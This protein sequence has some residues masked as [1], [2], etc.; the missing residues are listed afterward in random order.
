LSSLLDVDVA[1]RK[2]LEKFFTLESETLP[3]PNIVGRVLAENIV[4][5]IDLPIF[6]N[7]SMDGF[8]VRSIDLV[9]ASRENPQTL[10]VVDDI[11]AGKV[12]QFLINRDQ[13]S[14][15]MTGA[16]LPM[17]ADA[18]VPLEDTNQ[19]KPVNQS[20]PLPSKIKVFRSVLQGD[21]VRHKGED[22]KSGEIVLSS[23]KRIRPQE[24]GLLAMLGITETPIVRKPRIAIMS[25]GN[26]LVPIDTPLQVGQIHDSNTYTLR[27]QIIR[28]GGELIYSG[29]ASDLETAVF[30]VLTN[31]VS[32]DVDM[33][34]STAGVSV[35]A[36]DFV[37]SV[38]EQHGNVEFW[39]VNMR[40]GKPLTFGDFQG[41]PFIGLPGNP[42]SAF[43]SYEIF[44]RPAIYRM[45]GVEQS[46]QLIVQVR[47][48]DPVESDG[49]ESYL[50]AFVKRQEDQWIARLTGHQGSGNLR[51]LI[52]ANALLV[53]PSGVKSL[54]SNSVLDAI[55]FID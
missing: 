37:K 21:Y 32:S 2:I 4:S 26:E 24:I 13:T 34:I 31:A 38:I 41:I 17:G 15:I 40:P 44:V 16:P 1:R 36:F 3:I 49:R 28:D 33:I 19:F 30:E 8:A 27:A 6:P 45:S 39:R 51:S 20:E 9:G 10:K 50:R 43:V 55:I 14:R 52:Q 54:P 11:P 22:I 53:I 47:L 18:V 29:I 7:S 35:G 48:I 12:S 46:E 42:V 25:T 5:G 23:G